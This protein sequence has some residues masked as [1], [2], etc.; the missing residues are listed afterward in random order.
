MELNHKSLKLEILN[1]QKKKVKK[2]NHNTLTIC[3]TLANTKDKPELV[4]YLG[5]LLVTQ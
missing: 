4:V 5:R 3:Q 2:I 1:Q